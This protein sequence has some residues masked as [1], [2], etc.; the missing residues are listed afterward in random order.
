[1]GIKTGIEHI[2]TNILARMILQD[3]SGQCERI[4]KLFSDE[5]KLF[6]FD[7]AAMMELVFVLTGKVYNFSREE[8]SKKIKSVMNLENLVC[9]KSIIESALDLYVSHPKLSFVDCYLAIV[10]ETSGE[11]PLWTFDH[12]LISQCSFAREP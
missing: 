8:V 11:T 6:V 9:N 7:A 5:D 2:D 1:M 3:N 12:K 4:R 10:T